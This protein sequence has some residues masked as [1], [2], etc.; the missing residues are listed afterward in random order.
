M[1]DMEKMVTYIDEAGNEI[2][3]KLSDLLDEV[4]EDFKDLDET[5][6]KFRED[7]RLRIEENE[8]FYAGRTG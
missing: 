4:L 5:D 7:F 1:S 3:I 6:K 2:D 8:R